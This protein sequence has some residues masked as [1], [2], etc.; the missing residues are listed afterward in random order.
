MLCTRSW[1]PHP[2]YTSLPSAG[3]TG[4]GSSPPA[5]Q[6]GVRLHQ[7]VRHVSAS[8]ILDHLPKASHSLGGWWTP[9]PSWAIWQQATDSRLAALAGRG[10]RFWRPV[11]TSQDAGHIGRNLRDREVASQGVCT[12]RSPVEW[13]G[14]GLWVL[15][16]G[17]RRH[18][19][20][21]PMRGGSHDHQSPRG[22]EGKLRQTMGVTRQSS[23]ERGQREPK[24]KL[25]LC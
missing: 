9:S 11:A 20:H 2:R 17:P 14:K 3:H 8:E 24:R 4:L 12:L 21:S 1:G 25:R 15:G 22:H 23:R 10:W 5:H 13:R 19:T 6:A 7:K 18:R 16:K